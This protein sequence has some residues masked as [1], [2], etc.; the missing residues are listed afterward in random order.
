MFDARHDCARARLGGGD[1]ARAE[2]KAV[3]DLEAHLLAGTQAG[4]GNRDTILFRLYMAFGTDPDDLMG[5]H[6][7]RVPIQFLLGYQA[8]LQ[9]F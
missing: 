6:S 4:P 8:N 9:L 2:G 1:E 7:F 3:I 5:T